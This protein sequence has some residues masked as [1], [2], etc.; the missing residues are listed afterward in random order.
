MVMPR[1]GF[2][3]FL[4]R[5]GLTDLAEAVGGAGTRIADPG[6]FVSF[7]A[8]Q[9]GNFDQARRRQGQRAQDALLP[10]LSG[11][12]RQLDATT[13]SQLRA[14]AGVPSSTEIASLEEQERQLLSRPIFAGDPAQGQ[15]QRLREQLEAIPSQ[16]PRGFPV[17]NVGQGAALVVSPQREL[18]ASFLADVA[19]PPAADAGASPGQATAIGLGA[20]VLGGG[21]ELVP[22]AGRA[23]A[24]G[25]R[26]AGRGGERLGEEVG[27]THAWNALPGR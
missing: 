15:A 2:E 25:G 10:G 26:A 6:R 4:D 27:G 18:I 16:P 23:L 8:E 5:L 19:G 17:A 22:L 21:P 7:V 1:T 20:G 24:A 14:V 12:E 3:G 13:E 9:V 11:R